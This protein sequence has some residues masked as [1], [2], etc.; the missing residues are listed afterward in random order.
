V[1]GLGLSAQVT[2]IISTWIGTQLPKAADAA[3]RIVGARLLGKALEYPEAWMDGHVQRLRDKS[4][5][6]S[7][8]SDAIAKGAAERISGG[9]PLASVLIE[10]MLAGH[11]RKLSNKALVFQRAI[12]HISDDPQTAG[13][14]RHIPENDWLNAFETISQ[15]ITS[16]EMRERFARLLAGEMKKPGSFSVATL[17]AISGMNQLLAAKFAETCR[18]LIGD[19]IFRA[20]KY[21]IGD[22]WN[23]ICMLRDEGLFSPIDSSIHEPTDA[24]QHADGNYYWNVGLNNCFLRIN[25]TPGSRSEIPVFNLTNVGREIAAILPEANYANNLRVIAAENKK[26]AGWKST[27]LL[28]DG[29]VIERL[30]FGGS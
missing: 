8:V 23:Q 5:A 17:R 9:D 28:K 18:E 1:Y 25:F 4:R 10:D 22:P 2:G 13:Q 29:V 24:S 7:I 14:A 6:N 19:L 27:E 20:R 30:P 26:I 16:D 3:L 12:E 21:D 15:D 11:T